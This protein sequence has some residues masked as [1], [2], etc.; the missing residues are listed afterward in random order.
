ME[1]VLYC[2]TDDGTA[3][4]ERRARLLDQVAP[5]LLELGAHHVSVAVADD[6]VAPAAPLRMAMSDAPAVAVA[7]VWVDSATDHLRAP[8]DR[9]FDAVGGILS[10]YLVTE[11]VPLRATGTP[12]ERLPGMAQVAFLRRPADLDVAT[13]RHRWLDLHT[14]VAI[15]TQA[16]FSYVQHAVVRVLTPGAEPW[17]AIVEECFPAEAMTSPHAFF[18][19]VGDDDLLAAHQRAML[20]SV[21]GF[22]DLGR[23][24][25][26]PASRYDVA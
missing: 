2:V 18:D 19:A 11:S 14:Q 16:T 25:V 7:S 15:D 1:K 20:E 9:A 10:A 4:A 23:I 3:P 13:W 8:F 26:L 24:D 17:D 12:G 21:Q 22:I 6:D 5:R